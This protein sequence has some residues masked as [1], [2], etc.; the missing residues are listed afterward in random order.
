MLPV[1][2]ASTVDKVAA[3]TSIGVEVVAGKVTPAGTHLNL[4]KP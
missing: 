1:P 2:A 4:E 3:G